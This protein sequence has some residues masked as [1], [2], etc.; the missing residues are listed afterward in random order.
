MNATAADSPKALRWFYVLPQDPSY[1]GE[2]MT[3]IFN[4]GREVDREHVENLL[5]LRWGRAPELIWAVGTER[6]RQ[7]IRPEELRDAYFAYVDPAGLVLSVLHSTELCGAYNRGEYAPHGEE[8]RAL[9]TKAGGRAAI[10]LAKDYSLRETA[11]LTSGWRVTGQDVRGLATG[12]PVPEPEPQPTGPSCPK[13]GGKIIPAHECE[14]CSAYRSCPESRHEGTT[15]EREQLC[16]ACGQPEHRG[17]MLHRC[18]TDDLVA[19]AARKQAA[20]AAE[21]LPAYMTLEEAQAIGA[22][23]EACLRP[24]RGG[25]YVQSEGLQIGG[26]YKTRRGALRAAAR[27][28]ASRSQEYREAVAG[29]CPSCGARKTQDDE[30]PNFEGR[31]G[32]F[33]RHYGCG[34]SRSFSGRL[35][36]FGELSGCRNAES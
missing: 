21:E 15:E 31:Q 13:R 14:T 9:I 26:L 34:A 28:L 2:P 30:L 22:Q 36:P 8:L 27:L 6:P 3:R 4:C 7:A 16:P 18:H 25:Y 29:F 19:E 32:L 20:A 23:M 11:T 5:A 24:A 17:W 10:R 35:V 1:Q 33:R 12:L